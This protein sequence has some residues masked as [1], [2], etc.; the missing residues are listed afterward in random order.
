M[1]EYRISNGTEE[2]I[3]FGYT[4][5]DACRRAGINPN[6]WTPFSWEYID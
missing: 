6:E 3:I 2:D 5:E 4:F 1:W